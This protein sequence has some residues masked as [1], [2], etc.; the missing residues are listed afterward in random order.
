MNVRK[1]SAADAA[2]LAESRGIEAEQL[3]AYAEWVAAHAESHLPFVAEVDGRIAGVAWLLVAARVP[4]SKGL[5]RHYG[6]VQSVQVR[7][8]FRNRGIGTAL[9]QAILDEARA[10]RLEHVTVHSSR[11][12]VDFY[13]RNG[14]SH[15]REHLF[16]APE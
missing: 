9:I 2:A 13:L 1:A 7:E 5:D 8:E 14:F 4:S 16:W 15:H 3:P 10:R 11:R 6:D 12:A